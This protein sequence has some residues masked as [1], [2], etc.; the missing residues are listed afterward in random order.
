MDYEAIPEGE[1]LDIDKV[2]NEEVELGENILYATPISA[3][4]TAKAISTLQGLFTENS[5]A[6]KTQTLIEN[7]NT[8]L[9]KTN[10]TQFYT[11]TTAKQNINNMIDIKDNIGRLT[12]YTN[13][14]VVEE[15]TNIINQYNEHLKNLKKNS[16][17]ELL[18]KTA[19]NFNKENHE[20]DGFPKTKVYEIMDGVAVN[21]GATAPANDPEFEYFTGDQN[22]RYEYELIDSTSKDNEIKDD[23]GYVA[24]VTTTYT[25]KY[26]VH[27]YK[28]IK[29][30]NYLSCIQSPWDPT[31]EEIE[32]QFE[33]VGCPLPYNKNNPEIK[34]DPTKNDSWGLNL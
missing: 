34:N 4:E 10:S 24:S 7:I 25:N 32:A 16:R 17:R 30:T 27:K 8:S 13:Q 15:I 28:Q 31:F 12:N 2:I 1:R 29:C 18:E 9:A 11:G 19:D 5:D 14:L 21:G 6:A 33:K 22:T 26:K 23:T 3:E 20:W